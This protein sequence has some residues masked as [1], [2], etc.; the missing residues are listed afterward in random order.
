MAARAK[1]FGQGGQWKAPG[2]GTD[3]SNPPSTREEAEGTNRERRTRA[4]PDPSLTSGR[5]HAARG[6]GPVPV[7]PHAH[8]DRAGC[9]GW[10]GPQVASPEGP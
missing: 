5:A 10:P 4:G 8:R 2:D 1:P 7:L 9:W 3:H 6:P